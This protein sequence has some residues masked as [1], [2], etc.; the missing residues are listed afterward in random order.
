MGKLAINLDDETL[1]K[2]RDV[3]SSKNTTLDEMVQEF[4]RS[5]AQQTEPDRAKAAQL[6]R[7]SFKKYG[8][9]MGPRTWSREDLYER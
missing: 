6:L 4:V 9:K 5:L 2:A 7:E 1:A 3:A 8:R